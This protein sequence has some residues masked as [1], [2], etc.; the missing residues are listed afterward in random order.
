[1]FGSLDLGLGTD[2]VEGALGAGGGIA[3]I[4]RPLMTGRVTGIVLKS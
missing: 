2:T 1:M 4:L 3:G